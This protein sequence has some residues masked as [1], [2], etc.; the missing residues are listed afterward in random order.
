[1]NT[2]C[3]VL[4]FS[5]CLHKT[6]EIKVQV[7]LTDA[8]SDETVGINLHITTSMYTVYIIVIYAE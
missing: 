5:M 2:L 8:R 7:K 3:S 4:R 6:Q 1:M